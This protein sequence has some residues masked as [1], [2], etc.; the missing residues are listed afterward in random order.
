M[1]DAV[2][3]FP[4][5]SE[6]RSKDRPPKSLGRESLAWVF[7]GLRASPAWVTRQRN[8]FTW[9]ATG[10]ATRVWAE[11][12]VTHD[13]FE[14]TRLNA[15]TA[16]IRDVKTGAETDAVLARLNRAAV[17]DAIV[18]DEADPS[19]LTLRSSVFVDRDAVK[20]TGLLL[21]QAIGLQALQ[22]HFTHNLVTPR[23]GGEPDVTPHPKSG[24]R[25][26]LEASLRNLHSLSQ[27]FAKRPSRFEG[28]EL[29]ALL[30]FFERPPCLLAN[31]DEA[32][33]VAEFPFL[34]ESSLLRLSAHDRHGHFGT[35]LRAS[36]TLPVGGTPAE[37][38]ELVC[39]LNRLELEQPTWMHFLGAWCDL[40]DGVTFTAF[41]PN[42]LFRRHF[43]LNIGLNFLV[44]A[45]WVAEKVFHDDWNR[46]PARSAV[47]RFAARELP[48]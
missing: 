9:W 18:R 29:P 27:E 19:R 22:A 35:G 23:T 33:L 3:P 20:D 36:L 4:P 41:Y 25:T 8:G 39:R 12:P 17:F 40:E 10:H 47:E 45:R 2:L 37:R 5:R 6:P 48:S 21:R 14:L 46:V 34:G 1:N 30:K 16:F 28:D 44:R 32:N 7:S 42:F 38:A 24:V 15:E 43:V 13:G 11:P 31:G 26:E